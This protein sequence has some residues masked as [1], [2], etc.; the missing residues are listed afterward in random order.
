MLTDYDSIYEEVAR[1]RFLDFD[2]LISLFVEIFQYFEMVGFSRKFA[3][4]QKQQTKPVSQFKKS[5]T[6]RRFAEECRF[7]RIF[8]TYSM[9]IGLNRL[10]RH[11]RDVKQLT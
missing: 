2:G 5:V 11:S 10:R 3:D 8:F 6:W 7:Q 9:S 4:L 1:L